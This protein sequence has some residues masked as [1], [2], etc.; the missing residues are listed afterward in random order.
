MS[1]VQKILI[2]ENENIECLTKF[3]TTFN[4]MLREKSG[5]DKY[6]FNL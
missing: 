4:Q 3:W 5:N 2:A 6:M 1:E